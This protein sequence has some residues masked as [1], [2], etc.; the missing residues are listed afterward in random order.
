MKKLWL[1]KCSLSLLSLFLHVR[2]CLCV[3]R[4]FPIQT[5][6]SPKSGVNTGCV[7]T[8]STHQACTIAQW[9]YHHPDHSR[10]PS[11]W[12]A[13]SPMLQPQ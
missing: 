5:R 1:V 13:R 11:V 9:M 8:L 2:A 6:V 12:S 4:H 3:C 10:Q 7:Q